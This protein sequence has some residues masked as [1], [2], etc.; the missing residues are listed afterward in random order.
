MRIEEHQGHL[1][2][3]SNI[4]PGENWEKTFSNL[5]AFTTQVR[6]R[7]EADSFGIGL[8]L[9]SQ[10]SIELL[11]GEQLAQ[12]KEWLSEQ[13][14][15][16]FTINGFPYG[17]FHEQRVKDQVHAPDWSSPDRLAYT[18][19][20]FQILAE[21]LPAEMDGGVSTSP[22]SYRFW[23]QGHSEL[24]LAKST[25]TRQLSELV[26]FLVRL[27]HD[28]GKSLHLD[29]E[30]EPDGI[31]ETSDEFI[32]F[33]HDHMLKDGLALVAKDVGCSKSEAKNHI[34][35]HFQ[36]CYDVCHFAVGYENPEEAITKF[37]KAGIRIG[38]IQIS[39]ALG[40]PQLSSENLTVI[41][42]QLETFDEPVYLHQA[43]VRDESDSLRRFKD[44]GEALNNLSTT[45]Q[46]IRTHFHVPVF[47]QT[48]D[49]LVSTQSDIVET[50]QV[51]L[52]QNFTNHLEV[53]TYTWDVLPDPLRTDLVSSIVRELNWVRKTL[54]QG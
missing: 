49:Q 24:E 3:C 34:A 16:V 10:A 28:T 22:L 23:H 20:L 30:P 35:E 31:L 7:L 45:D 13:K 38:R 46:E 19:R 18:K 42:Q 47:T 9:S 39:A 12:F 2:Y 48:Y 37:Q 15:Y 43:V 5:K 26:T 53:E 14:M 6:D 17:Q 29:M 40:S 8:R 44:L 51:W 25:A 32:D 27:K 41:R 1:T 52:A 36:L 21:L 33:F 50:L 54:K 11:Q 4:H